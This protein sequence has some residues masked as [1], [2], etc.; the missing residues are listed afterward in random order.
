MPVWSLRCTHASTA[1]RI[2]TLKIWEHL[3]TRCSQFW[4]SELKLRSQFCGPRRSRNWSLFLG[5][6]VG[7]GGRSLGHPSMLPPDRSR[8]DVFRQFT[9]PVGLIHPT[10]SPKP[11]KHLRWWWLLFSHPVVSDSLWPHELQHNRPP[12]PSPSP[13]VCPTPMSIALVM[14][15]SHHILWHLLVSSVFSQDQGLLQWVGC[16][17]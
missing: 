12:C 11:G 13:E 15:S 7:S 6:W 9:N 8:M 3:K 14:P 5:S 10:H 1:A 2:E 4:N 17:H 16:L